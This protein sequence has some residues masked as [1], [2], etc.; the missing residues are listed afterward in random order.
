[1]WPSRKC[2]EDGYER[3]FLASEVCPSCQAHAW[4]RCSSTEG[5]LSLHGTP[6][7]KQEGQTGSTPPAWQALVFLKSV[8]GRHLQMVGTSKAIT[9]QGVPGG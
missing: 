7:G 9:D 1:M 8:S 4:S 3:P 5:T 2:S 6:G